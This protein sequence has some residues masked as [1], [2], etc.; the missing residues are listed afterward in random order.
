MEEKPTQLGARVFKRHREIIRKLAKKL[1]VSEAEIVR[2]A[3]QEKWER[4]NI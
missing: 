2:A 4:E 1:N 3:I